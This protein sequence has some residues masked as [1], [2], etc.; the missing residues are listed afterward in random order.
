MIQ[1]IQSIYLFLVA[2]LNSLLFILPLNE[3]VS[4]SHI[5]R[6]SI[7]G[8]SDI[9]DHGNILIVDLFPLLVIVSVSILLSLVGIF[10]FKNRKIQMRL[11]MYTSILGLGTTFLTFFYAY[12]IT[13]TNSTE[14]GFSVGLLLP[15]ISS[16]FAFL[17]FRAIKRDDKL[18][19]SVDR[20]R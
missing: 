1:R 16:I 18:I 12:Q 17:A 19:K 7:F 11:S 10:L 4:G 20:I 3:M 13:S 15:I 8:L 5:L 14:L 6:L 2:I 9:T